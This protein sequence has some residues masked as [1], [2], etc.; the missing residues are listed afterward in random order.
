M[1]NEY[2][3]LLS[4]NTHNET[5]PIAPHVIDL[6]A[7]RPKQGSSLSAYANILCAVA[8]TGTLSLPYALK[9]GGWIG[10]GVLILSLLMSIYA[11][12]LLM[13]CLYYDGRQRLSSYQEVGRHAFGRTGLIAV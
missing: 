9:M 6:L 12:I 11:A 4:N 3:P 13:K 7:K 1:N 10:V 2:T 5:E 8:G